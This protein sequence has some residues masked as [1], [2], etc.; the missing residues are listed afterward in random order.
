MEEFKIGK[1]T[2]ELPHPI[3]RHAVSERALAIIAACD[4]LKPGEFVPVECANADAARRLAVIA[5][6]RG[7]SLYKAGLVVSQ[8]GATV[9]FYRNGTH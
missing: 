6:D 5:R 1:P 8:R 3:K 7:T 2:A 9:Y 4:G